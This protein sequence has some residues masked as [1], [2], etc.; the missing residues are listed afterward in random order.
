MRR[1]RTGWRLA[2]ASWALL[3]AD[4]SLAAFPLLGFAAALV[5]VLILSV[6]AVALA[7]ITG[8]VWLLGP[9]GLLAAYAATFAAV[10]YG[11][12][13]SAAAAR[14]FDGHDTTLADG[15]AAARERR[16]LVARW[17]AVQLAVGLVISALEAA[18]SNSPAARVFG[19]LLGAAASLAWGV[20][21]FFVVPLLALEGL[22]PKA[23]L[24]RS[25]SIVR[26]RWGEGIAGTASIGVAVGVVALVPIVVLA[27]FAAAVCTASPLVGAGLAAA[28]VLVAL[29]TAAIATALSA[30]FRV[31]LLRYATT[32]TQ[33]GGFAAADL[34]GAFRR[35]YTQV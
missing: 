8:S 18:L 23:A 20:A 31:A 25:G 13:L 24:A 29:A 19:S 27:A 7:T 5:A 9:F 30:I 16:G 35:Q 12:A 28:A 17:A 6:P 34:D 14:S 11:V 21:T 10:Y 3:R 4:R 32:G 2:R 22:G 26:Q 1:I 15:L 33:P